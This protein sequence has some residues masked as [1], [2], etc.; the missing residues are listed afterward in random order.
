MESTLLKACQSKDSE[1]LS[2]FYQTFGPMLYGICLRYCG[3]EASAQDAFHDFFLYIIER[4]HLYKGKGSFQS[5]LYRCCVN[6]LINYLKQKIRWETTP[7]EENTEIEMED[8]SWSLVPLE[9]LYEW[10]KAL[11]DGFRTVFNLRA[12]EGYDYAAIAQ[13]LGISESSV[14]SQYHR[15]RKQLQK[16]LKKFLHKHHATI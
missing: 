14:R 13:M 8:E 1:A 12:I 4:L 10:V 2:Y 7:L 16:Q 9:T 15:A 3:E 11:P 5:W 6:F